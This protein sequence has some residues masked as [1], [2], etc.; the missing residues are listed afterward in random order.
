MLEGDKLFLAGRV[1]DAKAIAADFNFK[2]EDKCLPVLLSSKKGAEALALCPD[3]EAHG[4]LTAACHKAPKGF[5]T[6]QIMKKYSQSATPAQL[7]AAGW[8]PGAKKTRKT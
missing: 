7:K 5:D 6:Y 2:L 3:H 1:Y 4:G 8:S